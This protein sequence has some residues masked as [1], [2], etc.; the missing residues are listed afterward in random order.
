MFLLLLTL[1]FA[2][3]A[4]GQLDPR[5]R[6]GTYLGS[7][8]ADCYEPFLNNCD[9]VGHNYFPANSGASVVTMD[10]QGNI[11]VAGGTSAVDFPTT[12]GAYRRTAGYMNNGFGDL[13]SSDSFV[14]KFAPSGAL[15]W[16]TYLLVG[17]GPGLITFDSAGNVIVVGGVNLGDD[18]YPFYSPFIAKLNP[19][20]TA[21]LSYKLLVSQDC[22]S[23]D[24]AAFGG[25]AVDSSGAIYIAGSSGYGG[26][27]NGNCIV[28]TPG[29]NEYGQGFVV[30]L[31]SAWSKVYAARVDGQLSGIAVDAKGN[32]WV[33]GEI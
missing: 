33:T 9:Q 12:P 14:A 25:A 10:K 1:L 15:V 5:V 13:F 32:V 19:N 2:V 8:L 6:Y 21:I 27:Y 28:T 3:Q 18:R 30:K 24:G 26:A 17:A 23:Y 11:F 16:S 22:S 4:F 20:G 31:N 7:S 29:A